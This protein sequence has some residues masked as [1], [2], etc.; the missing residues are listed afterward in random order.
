MGIFSLLKNSGTL[1]KI[2]AKIQKSQTLTRSDFELLQK[3]LKGNKTLVGTIFKA[4][5]YS[6]DIVKELERITLEEMTTA[7]TLFRN[8]EQNKKIT[9][10]DF[11]FLQ[12]MLT[13]KKALINMV[14]E[15]EVVRMLHKITFDDV[16][17]LQP[18]FYKIE[19]GKTLTAAER[20]T[21]EKFG[22]TVPSKKL[23]L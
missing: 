12:R 14:L 4:V 1:K 18:I 7:Q 15:E 16:Q 19:Q 22:G 10:T 13:D 9:Q 21:W 23:R 5:G 20:T 6:E 17:E 3:E 8:I 2:A 11:A